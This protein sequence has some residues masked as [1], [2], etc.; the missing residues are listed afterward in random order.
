MDHRLA[1]AGDA[2]GAVEIGVLDD[3]VRR[4]TYRRAQSPRGIG[5]SARNI[6]C[7]IV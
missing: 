3:P 6:G 5:M 2:A 4:V 1:R 7:D